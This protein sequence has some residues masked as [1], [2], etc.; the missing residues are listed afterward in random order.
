MKRHRS[1]IHVPPSSPAAANVADARDEQQPR[2]KRMDDDGRNSR[3]FRRHGSHGGG[4]RRD[5]GGSSEVV[6]GRMLLEKR[7]GGGVVVASSS[8]AA[9][10]KGMKNHS[11]HYHHHHHHYRHH[12][13]RASFVKDGRGFSKGSAA[14][15]TRKGERDREDKGLDSDFES[16]SR[17]ST[18]DNN[19]EGADNRKGTSSATRRERREVVD[20][21]KVMSE[22][23]KEERT[24]K[25]EMEPKEI[26]KS[27][28]MVG[29]AEEPGMSNEREE[30]E[31]ESDGD[32]TAPI[33][34]QEQDQDGLRKRETDEASEKEETESG[35]AR[36]GGEERGG[37]E[38][39]TAPVQALD[40]GMGKGSNPNKEARESLHGQGELELSKSCDYGGPRDRGTEQGPEVTT[41]VEHDL[42]QQAR[43]DARGKLVVEAPDEKELSGENLMGRIGKGQLREG[44]KEMGKEREEERQIEKKQRM[45]NAALLSLALPDTSLSLSSGDPHGRQSLPQQCAQSHP[46]QAA[47]RTH[48]TG[49]TN[50]ISVSHSQPF[51]H[52]PSCSL[53]QTSLDKTE[54][55]SGSQQIS[56]A[57][58]QG[59]IGSWQMSYRSKHAN[60][61]FLAALA[62]DRQRPKPL[63]QRL[64]QSGNNPQILQGSLG[65]E[66][67]QNQGRE[68]GPQKRV[69]SRE[70]GLLERGVADSEKPFT[71][72]RVQDIVSESIPSMA[73]KLQELPDSFLE[74]L[75]ES[76]RDMLNSIDKREQFVSLQQTLAARTD[77]TTDTLLRAHRVQL[78]LLVAV[79]TGILA[80][81]HPDI[82]MTHSALVE[83]F[84]QTKCRNFACQSQLP[85]DECD[86]KL[87]AQKTGFC[88]SCMCVVCSK[89]DF[90]ANT[91]RWIGCDFCLHWCHTD[92]GIRMGYIAPGPSI[93]GAAGTSEMQFHCIACDHT[94]ELYGFVKDVFCTCAPQWD[95]DVLASELDCVR[96]IFHDSKD[97]HGQQLCSKAEQM[98]QQLDAQVDPAIACS[99]MLKFFA[100]GDAGRV[101]NQSPSVSKEAQTQPPHV[102]KESLRTPPVSGMDKTTTRDA[103]ER[104][105]AALQTYDAELEEKRQEAAELQQEREHKK[106][107]ILELESIVRIKQAEAK[108]FAVRAGEAR[109]EA[110]GLQ[111]IVLAKAEKI[112]QEY[113]FKVAKL[114]LEEAEDRCRTGQD[115]VQVLHQAQLDFHALKLPLLTELHDLLKQLE[116]TKRQSWK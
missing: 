44:E 35:D 67:P 102:S 80:F 92:C 84:L 94:S 76:L 83:V 13:S 2:F 23:N 34:A 22:S 52:N 63:Y 99:T 116:A 68:G 49:F 43:K 66:R 39:G 16:R 93:R 100:D 69:P 112:E 107:Q 20:N 38:I 51:L 95:R 14:D 74:G 47:T 56:Q 90:D 37:E 41:A 18:R 26:S 33:A 88:S 60:E 62:Q 115:T 64:L 31:M 5:N 50:S 53:T 113:A 111:R 24:E 82:P 98:L 21:V 27:M 101:Q 85:A 86:C 65:S 28:E 106:A 71:T 114:R 48:S 104:A 19:K 30:G 4:D 54:L 58:E 40:S 79:K 97:A 110:E 3:G 96:R 15:E 87:C 70:K 8:S 103:L 108:M 10:D 55:S 42:T 72:V 6:V 7:E 25:Q 11:H 78:E 75:K 91:C 61:G 59:S 32:V 45:E 12:H 29:A 46:S 89:F 77:L 1:L 9:A 105:R 81:L 36:I 17:N 73:R 109:R 57:K